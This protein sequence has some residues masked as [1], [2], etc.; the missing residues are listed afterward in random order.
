MHVARVRTR[1][2]RAL[3][4]HPWE[5]RKSARLFKVQM[6]LFLNIHGIPGMLMARA[7]GGAVRLGVLCEGGG[8]SSNACDCVGEGWAIERSPAGY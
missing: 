1:R 7:A 3:C 2:R 5:G 6:L 8:R 4:C